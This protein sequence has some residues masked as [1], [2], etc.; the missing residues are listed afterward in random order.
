MLDKVVEYHL[1][2]VKRRLQDLCC[3]SSE[4]SKVAD[5]KMGKIIK[6]NSNENVCMFYALFNALQPL[7]LHHA[8]SA[9]APG[10]NY[11]VN[12]LEFMKHEEKIKAKR[13]KSDGFTPEDMRRYLQWL[14]AA[15][16]IKSYLWLSKTD[17]WKPSTTLCCQTNGPL[18]HLLS[19]NATYGDD[20]DTAAALIRK[21]REDAGPKLKGPALWK[22]EYDAYNKWS[23]SMNKVWTHGIA[24]SSV[25]KK[26]CI[27]DTARNK[28]VD[29]TIE[30][31]SWSVHGIFAVHQFMIT[32]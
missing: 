16:F 14:K 25:N 11:C 31:L 2:S 23:D 6:S 8:F 19:A 24:V 1:V 27:F 26:A 28:V 10:P 29:F 17:K 30:N 18:I 15:G 12:Y 4:V 20:R 21:A 32:V 22:L 13:I 7:G 5:A 9:Y 3:P